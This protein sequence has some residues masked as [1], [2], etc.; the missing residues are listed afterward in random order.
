MAVPPPRDPNAS[1]S[2]TKLEQHGIDHI[3]E[4]HR[5]SRPRNIFWIMAG[6]SVTYPLILPGWIPISLGLSWWESFWAIVVGMIVGSVLLMPMALLSPHTGT[7]NPVGSS[8]HFGAV[9]RIV[10]SAIGFAQAVLFAA[11]AIWTGGDSIAATLHRLFGIADGTAIRIFWYTVLSVFVV[12]VAVF[13]HGMM[14][15]LQRLA[16]PT[17]GGILILGVFVFMGRFDPS[18]TGTNYALDGFWPTWVAGGIPSALVVVGYGLAIGDWTRYISPKRFSNVQVA[19]G[20]FAGGVI[21][22]GVPALFGAY[23][24]TMFADPAGNFVNELVAISPMWFVYCLLY[25]G[26]A[27]GSAQGTVNMYSTGLDISSMI[28]RISRVPGTLFVGAAAYILVLFGTFFGDIVANL[29]V[30]LDLMII[31]FVS[32]VTVVAVGFWNHRGQYD[33]HALQSFVRGEQGGRY[34]FSGGWN[35]RALAAFLLASVIGL[36]AVNTAWY[37]GFLVPYLGG[38]GVGFMLSVIVGAGTYVLLLW[39]FPEDL[40]VYACGEPRIRRSTSSVIAASQQRA[41]GEAANVHE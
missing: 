23:V 41:T 31:P 12:T 5:V 29:T 2:L 24:A 27:T 34:W 25:L 4:A 40:A 10:G 8:A 6:S 9:G 35:Y 37:V 20:T 3:P 36:C 11:L 38:L 22:M 32:F 19:R 33:N 18:Y 28:P 17:A 16:A 30:S 13:G 26:L 39:T 21:G 7:N 1:G 14:L 15:F